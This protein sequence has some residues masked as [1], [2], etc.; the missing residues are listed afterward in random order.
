MTYT[1]DSDYAPDLTLQ[2]D[3]SQE[4]TLQNI[5]CLLNTC[6]AEVPCYRNFGM[7]M[8]YI[9]APMNIAKTMLVSAIADALNEFF[10]KLRL[11]NVEFNFDSDY[12]D[13][14]GCRIEVTDNNE[15]S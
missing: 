8:S 12:P 11:E 1:L 13:K 3:S 9:S 14:I 4:E 6:I 10:P 2:P 7:D 15:E 5:Y